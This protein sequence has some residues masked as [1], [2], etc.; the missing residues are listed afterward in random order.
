MNSHVADLAPGAV[1]VGGAPEGWDAKLLADLVA[2]AKGP[3]IHVARDDARAANLNES[4]GFFAP[5]LPVL[6][7]PA[8]DCLPYDLVSPN[9]EIS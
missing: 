4:L 9:P 2:R 7:F 5:G 6:S 3:V 8:W 1:T